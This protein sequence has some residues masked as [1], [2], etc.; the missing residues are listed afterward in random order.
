VD[1]TEPIEQTPGRHLFVCQTIAGGISTRIEAKNLI[2]GIQV[3]GVKPFDPDLSRRYG[4][5][6]TGALQGLPSF[7]SFRPLRKNR[8]IRRARQSVH[9]AE[10]HPI[11]AR[12][13]WV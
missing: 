6:P 12:Y 9:G 11:E 5:W 8:P 2:V 1:D 3:S 13:P 7:R 10:F 4:S